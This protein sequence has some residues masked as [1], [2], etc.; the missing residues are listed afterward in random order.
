MATAA[1][2]PIGDLSVADLSVHST[3]SEVPKYPNCYPS[4]NPVDGYRA[5][6]AELIAQTLD[7]SPEFVYPKVQWPS[8]LS[9]GDLIL[10]VWAFL[11]SYTL[12]ANYGA[13]TVGS[14]D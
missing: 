3:T 1:T 5:H 4:V 2:P 9:Q 12:L 6:I 7:L 10:P 14:A 8:N 13:P 11:F